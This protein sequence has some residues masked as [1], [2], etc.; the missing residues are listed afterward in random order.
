[1]IPGN[2]TSAALAA[3]PTSG[4]APRRWWHFGEDFSLALLLAFMVALPLAAVLREPVVYLQSHL[5]LELWG[6]LTAEE[7]A[8]IRARPAPQLAAVRCPECGSAVAHGD[9]FC[10]VCGTKLFFESERWAGET[11]VALAAFD[12]PVD[13]APT[14]DASYEEHV[15]WILRP[16]AAQQ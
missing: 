4:A 16:A 11:H 7:V 1:M 2:E 15:D 3:W 12:D 9:S 10:R 13:R 8:A 6:T 5:V 14:V